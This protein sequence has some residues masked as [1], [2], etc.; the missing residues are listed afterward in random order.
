[1]K[2]VRMAYSKRFTNYALTRS[3]ADPGYLCRIPDPDFYLSRIL[4]PKTASK[5]RSEK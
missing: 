2:T 4:D 1:M 3:I 5:E